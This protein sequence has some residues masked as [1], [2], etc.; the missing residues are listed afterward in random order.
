MSLV[1]CRHKYVGHPQ[2]RP[3]DAAALKF[4]DDFGAD[5]DMDD[6]DGLELGEEQSGA[7]AAF[8]SDLNR[9]LACALLGHKP[10]LECCGRMLVAQLIHST[11]MCAADWK[12][13]SLRKLGSAPKKVPRNPVHLAPRVAPKQPHFAQIIGIYSGM[14]PQITTASRCKPPALMTAAAKLAAAV[15]A[16]AAAPAPGPVPPGSSKASAGWLLTA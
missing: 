11:H 7:C 16:V 3:M 9:K 14:D 15:A 6:A 12:G 10:L 13:H 4:A 1:T 2:D 8:V 5:V